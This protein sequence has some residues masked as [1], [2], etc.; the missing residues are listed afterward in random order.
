MITFGIPATLTMI[1]KVLL[2]LFLVPFT[3]AGQPVMVTNNYT[4][5][6]GIY[7]SIGELVT[8]APRYLN[9]ELDIVNPPVGLPK[10]YY[11]DSLRVRHIYH[12]SCF[13]VVSGGV[14]FV[15]HMNTFLK[16]YYLGAITILFGTNWH[17][18]FQ[19]DYSIHDEAIFILDFGSGNVFPFATA[20]VLGLLKRDPVLYEE[21]IAARAD[22]AERSIVEFI[23]K[24]NNR[25]PVYLEKQ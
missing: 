20:P 16:S 8:N 15:R 2:C 23:L 21:L 18:V 17:S 10:Y 13:A 14:L 1:N 19:A 25:N 9:C 11:Y 22:K 12:D 7:T 5:A 3:L 24:Y 4:F 6:K